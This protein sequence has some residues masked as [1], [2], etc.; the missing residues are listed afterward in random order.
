MWEI[1]LVALEV[2][3][4]DKEKHE[5]CDNYRLGEYIIVA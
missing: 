4:R 1:A 2:T 5:T 3:K